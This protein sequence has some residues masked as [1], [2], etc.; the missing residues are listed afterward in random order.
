VD[1]SFEHCAQCGHRL[2][3]DSNS[4]TCPRCGCIRLIV[5]DDGVKTADH[6]SA[7]STDADGKERGFSESERDGRTASAEL[8]ED[9]TIRSVLTGVPPQGEDDTMFAA[10]LLVNVLNQR[11]GRWGTPTFGTGAV[12]AQVAEIVPS[13]AS[14]SIQV[15]RVEVAQ[16]LWMQLHRAQRVERGQAAATMSE[17]VR[18]AITHKAHSLPSISERRGIT[19]AIDA[20]RLPAYVFDDV[21]SRFLADHETWASTLGFDAIW[22]VG[23]VDVLVKQLA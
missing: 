19:L 20:N 15:V 11:G 7:L 3:V 5:N 1:S 10:R 16:D 9:G 13:G 2:G 18:N 22:I 23:P 8:L 6:L 14:L 21:I 12:D 17:T 4:T